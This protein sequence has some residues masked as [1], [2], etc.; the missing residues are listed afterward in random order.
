MQKVRSYKAWEE[1]RSASI[2]LRSTIG[3]F[4]WEPK[5]QRFVFRKSAPNFV[6]IQLMARI[7]T[8]PRLE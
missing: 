8:Q 7:A 4:R 5:I 2:W 1:A 6:K 3:F